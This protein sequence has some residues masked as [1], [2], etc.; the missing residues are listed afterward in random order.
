MAEYVPDPPTSVASSEP[1]SP[2][3]SE[4]EDVLFPYWEWRALVRREW[5]ARVRLSEQEHS[6]IQWIGEQLLSLAHRLLLN[7]ET[8]GRF[9]VRS[10]ESEACFYLRVRRLRAIHAQAHQ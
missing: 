2:P 7:E 8:A 4:D 1:P 10:L 6:D 5:A 3:F 9:W